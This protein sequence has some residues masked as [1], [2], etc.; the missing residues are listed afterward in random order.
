ME[1]F[2]TH[3]HLSPDRDNHEIVC[4]AQEAGVR[5]LLFCAGGVEDSLLLREFVRLHAGCFFAA[6][7]HPHEADAFRGDLSL[8]DPLAG[9]PRLRAIGEIGID[10]CY[11]FSGLEQQISVFHSMLELAL[12]WN[13]PA[14]VHCRAAEKSDDAYRICGE[15]LSAFA[16]QGGRFV[17]HCFSGTVEQMEQ[18]AET[19][20]YF[21]VGGMLTFK[22]ADNIRETVLRMPEERILLE[23][24]TPYLAPVPFRGKPNAPEY[25]PLVAHKLAEL[26]HLSVEQIAERTTR[27]AFRLFGIQEESAHGA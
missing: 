8:F 4:R 1:L 26:K 24:D 27:N 13:L 12:K 9:D 6:G 18:F 17:V 22:K 3:L 7:V 20:A 11:S 5:N 25:L 23:T 10:T 2:D 15:E 16:A 19:G 21:G 14:V